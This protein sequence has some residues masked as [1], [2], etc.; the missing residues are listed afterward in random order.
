MAAAARSNS[1]PF[2]DNGKVPA[3]DSIDSAYVSAAH[4]KMSRFGLLQIVRQRLG[5]SALS[6]S[7]EVCPCCNG[8]GSRRN[9]EWQALQSLKDLLRRLRH[10][11]DAFAKFEIEEERELAMYL[12]NQKRERLLELETT[13]KVSIEIKIAKA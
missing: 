9:M 8:S 3:F 12:L 4:G 2:G 13:Y 10:N 11:K 6:L 1:I 5:S 7:T